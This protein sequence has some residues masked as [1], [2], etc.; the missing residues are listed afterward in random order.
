MAI[1]NSKDDRDDSMG[2]KITKSNKMAKDDRHFLV[3]KQPIFEHA[4][5]RFRV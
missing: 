2:T 3:N 5:D 4:P 1:R